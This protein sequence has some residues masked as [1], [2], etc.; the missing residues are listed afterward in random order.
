MF[1]EVGRRVELHCTGVGKALLSRLEPADVSGIA[2]RN[3]LPRHTPHTITTEAA[4]QSEVEAI[5]AAGYAIDNEEQEMGVRCVAIAL[6]GD[7]PAP[8]AV[9]VSGPLGRVTDDFIARAVPLLQK[10]A[11]ELGDQFAASGRAGGIGR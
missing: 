1:T 11:R 4:L 10:A 5:R 9:S 2:R 8:M 7:F 6:P 3:G